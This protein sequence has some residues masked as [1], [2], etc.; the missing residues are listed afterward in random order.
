MFGILDSSTLGVRPTIATQNSDLVPDSNQF[1][2]LDVP[3]LCGTEEVYS[4]HISLGLPDD[5]FE[6]P[7]ASSVTGKYK[8]R[9]R[10]TPFIQM[11]EANVTAG[12]GREYSG[13]EKGELGF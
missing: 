2:A 3:D 11:A 10:N 12:E 6:A 7:H 4:S 1:A 9:K 5:L 13:R 8:D